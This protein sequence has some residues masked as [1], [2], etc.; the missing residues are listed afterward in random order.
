MWKKII[1]VSV[2][3]AFCL[4][5]TTSGFTV[6]DPQHKTQNYDWSK[7]K[8]GGGGYVPGIIFNPAEKDLIYARTDMGGA[9]R[10]DAR[11]N[12]WIQ[13]LDSV[14][15]DKANL[16]G[17][18]SLATD[19]V[20]PDRVYIAAG[21]YNNE[22]T[23]MKGVILRSQDRGKTWHSTELPF[24]FGANMPGR[25]MGER[26]AI[27]PNNNRI[28]YFGTRGDDLHGGTGNGLWRSNNYGVTWKKVDSFPDEGQFK[29]YFNNA[30]GIVWIVFDKNTGSKNKTTQTIYVGVGDKEGNNIYR[31]TDGGETWA[32]VPGQPTGYF[33]H[34]AVL[35]SNGMMYITY[36]SEIGPFGGGTGDVYKYD[37]KNGSWT[38]ISPADPAGWKPDGVPYGGV[39]VDANNPETVMVATLNMWWPDEFIFRSTDGG[40]TWKSLW[41]LDWSKPAFKDRKYD[42]DYSETPWLDW[43]DKSNTGANPKLGWMIGDLEIDPFNPDRVM[44]GTGASVMSSTNITAL[45]IDGTVNIKVLSKG[46]EENAI[47]SLISPPQGAHLLSAMP[48]LGGFRHEDLNKAPEMIMNPYIGGGTDLDYAESNPNYIVRVGD[49][50]NNDAGMGISAD[51]GITWQPAKNAW[52]SYSEK[53]GGGYVAVGADGK[54]ILWSPKGADPVWSPTFPAR[55]ISYSKD[56]GQTWTASAGIPEQARISSDRVNPNKF[57]GLKDGK[58][59][60][61]TDAGASFKITVDNGLPVSISSNFKVVPGREGDIWIAAAK[62]NKHLEY[63]YGLWHSTDSGITFKKIDSIEEAASVGLG[64]S[65]PGK[66]Y[67]ALYINGRVKGTYGI[68]RSD[69]AGSNWVRISDDQHQYANAFNAITGD[70]RIYGRVYVGTNGFGIA[71]GDISR[72]SPGNSP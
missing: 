26:L 22:W 61:T 16:A 72:S 58:F 11:S 63:P 17:V 46:I 3:L 54:T 9:Y 69:D 52:D 38:K 65:A 36:N 64:M 44:Y 41:K 48:D 45:D 67:M 43:G 10:W 12:S 7:V 20:D 47:N 24:K 55:P 57:Y 6:S 19:P 56:G 68:Y 59:Y 30:L 5:I 42:I 28:I 1:C 39:A 13:L 33:A 31:S 35:A 37:T 71:V 14:S 66:D 49:S 18:E 50:T 15:F 25:D 21:T 34:S 2:V 32:P 40:K 8:I 53:T 51:N 27:D 70:P 60:V 29:D 4:A 62:D 23:D